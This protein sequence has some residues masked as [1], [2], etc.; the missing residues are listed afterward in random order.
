MCA[1]VGLAIAAVGMIA[2]MSA[3]DK[4]ASQSKK[5]ARAQQALAD[6]SAEK[7]TA[8]NNA[9]AQEKK[10]YRATQAIMERGRMR[11][12]VGDTG[13]EGVG[14][15][16]LFMQSLFNEGKDTTAIDVNR[17]AVNEQIE[18][19]RKGSQI[20][21]SAQIKQANANRDMATISALGNFAGTAVSTAQSQ[22]WVK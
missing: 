4:A 13:L 14:A 16:Q 15:H 5:S 1:V 2:Q 20:Q 19:E 18:V 6:E 11:A 7:S 22:G 21:T 17:K 3:A 10:G 9:Q 12:A 8:Q